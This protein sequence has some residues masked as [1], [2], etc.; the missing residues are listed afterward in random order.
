[1]SVV[2][3]VARALGQLGDPRFWGVAL[4]A[5][6]LTL[7]LLVLFFALSG[8]G[9]GLNQGDEL[10]LP[11]IGEVSTGGLEIAVW[12]LAAVVGSAFLMLPVA[13]IFVSFLL[14]PIV[15]AVE[16]AHYA[17][18]PPGEAVPVARQISASFKLLV[19]LAVANL[20]ALV[21]YIF[22]PP[23]APFLFLGVNGWLLGREY[24]ELVGF[25]RLSPERTR[26]LRRANALPVLL[27][28]VA[29]TATLS[30]PIVN[31]IAPLVGVAAMVHLFHR[32]RGRTAD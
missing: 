29:I 20:L 22:V 31:L 2:G 24:F 11:W 32:V 1:M 8:W 17:H 26:S 9:L 25:R 5:L 30:I 21:G 23:L 6:A 10:T 18:L 28:G 15:D 4:K 13:A 27:I 14:D 16:R 3:D 12:I 7:G 19:A